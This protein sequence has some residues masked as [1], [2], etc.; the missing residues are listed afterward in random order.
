M[1]CRDVFTSA[2]IAMNNAQTSAIFR[3]IQY[4]GR[5]IFP[6]GVPVFSPS[7]LGVDR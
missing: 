4:D 5:R 6:K 2:R 7:F 3:S 1:R